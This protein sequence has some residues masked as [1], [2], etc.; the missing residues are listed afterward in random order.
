M[1][2]SD[3]KWE[4]FTHEELLKLLDYDENTGLF[5]RRKSTGRQGK[6]GDIAGGLSGQ[7]Y[8]DIGIFGKKYLAHKLAWFYVYGK[9]SGQLDHINH[10]RIDNR[11][12]NL[13]EVSSLENSRNKSKLR[14]NTSGTTG[15]NWNKSANKWTANIRINYK[16]IH[17]GYFIE[18]HEAVNARRNAE[19]LY[20]FHKNHGEER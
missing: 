18:Y 5:I 2:E 13:R 16:L 10:N 19:V 14:N 12:S 1:K 4:I 6:A 17:L 7:G 20:G 15:V 3:K 8:I 11:I 9:R